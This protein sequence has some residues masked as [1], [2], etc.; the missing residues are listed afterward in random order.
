MDTVKPR[1]RPRNNENTTDWV[2]GMDARAWKLLADETMKD[3]KTM[4]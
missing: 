3:G 4:G 2:S 1:Q